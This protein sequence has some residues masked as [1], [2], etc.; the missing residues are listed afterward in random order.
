MT[1]WNDG[2]PRMGRSHLSVSLDDPSNS[3]GMLSANREPI[4]V[5]D[6]R[7]ERHEGDGE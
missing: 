3:W 1:M 7:K 2:T 4:S 6:A 5:S